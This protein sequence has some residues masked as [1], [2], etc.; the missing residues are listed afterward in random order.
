[1]IYLFGSGTLL[2]LGILLVLQPGKVAKVL[3]NF[4]S[5]YPLIRYAGITQLTGRNGFVV[6]SGVC[7]IAI[8]ATIMML[9]VFNY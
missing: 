7:F 6:A 2:L 4:Y 5:N 1:M 8:G 3:Q 9:R